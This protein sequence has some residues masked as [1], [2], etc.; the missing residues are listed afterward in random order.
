MPFIDTVIT[1]M[2]TVGSFLQA[3]AWHYHR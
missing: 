3:W 2:I 1:V